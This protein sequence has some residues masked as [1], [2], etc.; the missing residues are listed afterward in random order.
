MPDRRFTI[1]DPAGLHARPAARFVQVASRFASRIVVR[2]ADR[3]ADAK[4]LVALL[5][6]TIRPSSEI[7]LVADGLDAEAAL[8]ALVEE[9]AP[10]IAPLVSAEPA[11]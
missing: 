10:Y 5:G 8:T 4:S 11:S 1:L 7:S 3:E 2:Q 6:L 9:L